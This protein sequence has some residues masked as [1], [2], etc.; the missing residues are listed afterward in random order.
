MFIEA[1][2]EGSGDDNWTT[3]LQKPCRI[4]RYMYILCAYG[5]R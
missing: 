2:D 1:K 4:Y 3:A 5:T